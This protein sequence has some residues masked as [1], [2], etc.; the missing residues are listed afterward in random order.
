MK[1]SIIVSILFGPS[2]VAAEEMIRFIFTPTVQSSQPCTTSDMQKI[3]AIFNPGRRQVRTSANVARELP[4]QQC[5][6]NCKGYTSPFCYAKGCS[7][8]RELND[9]INDRVLADTCGQHTA[10][11]N[12]TLNQLVSTN[13]VSASCKTF[14]STAK[15]APECY[16][17]VVYGVIEQ[18]ALWKI[19]TSSGAATLVQSDISSSTLTVCNTFNF[20]IEAVVNTCVDFVNFRLSGPSNYYYTRSEGSIPYS[21]FGD[22]NGKLD[23]K[24]LTTLGDYTL[25]I[26]PDGYDYKKKSYK[27]T[28]KNCP[29]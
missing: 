2:I 25:T 21:L 6:D 5:K 20:N 1:F 19:P 23:G 14:L 22:A 9:N 13:A 10:D 29:P 18:V 4:T 15:R 28:V 12:A 7:R 27:I 17:D 26:I 3:E 8:R 16:N 11:I 24:K